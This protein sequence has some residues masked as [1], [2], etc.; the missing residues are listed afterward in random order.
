MLDQLSLD[1][2]SPP[3]V[4]MNDSALGDWKRTKNDTDD[5]HSTDVAINVHQLASSYYDAGLRNCARDTF[6][7]SNN[8][9]AGSAR[10]R[11]LELSH[12]LGALRHYNDLANHVL[13]LNQQGV[14]VSKLLGEF[15]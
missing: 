2:L 1:P 11:L 4:Y 13:S 8:P 6:S 9:I 14:V 12:G 5:V 3:G 7:S 15:R 10:Q